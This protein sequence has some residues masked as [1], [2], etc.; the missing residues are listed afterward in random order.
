VDAQTDWS[1]VNARLRVLVSIGEGVAGG[2]DN[3]RHRFLTN[4]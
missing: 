4:F 2:P 1:G 3:S